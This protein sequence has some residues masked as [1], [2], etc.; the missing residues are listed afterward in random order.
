MS[1]E[2]LSAK[3]QYVVSNFND[4]YGAKRIRTIVSLQLESDSV[5]Y[6]PV[7]MIP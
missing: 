2:V 5:F 4:K 6:R 1:V 7:E 3:E